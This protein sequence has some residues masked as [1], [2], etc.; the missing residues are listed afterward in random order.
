MIGTEG[1]YHYYMDGEMGVTGSLLDNS[2]LLLAFIEGYNVLGKDNYLNIAINLADYSLENLYDW[3]SGGFFERNSKDNEIYAPGDNIIL[4]KPGQ[5]NGVIVYALLKLYKITNNDSYLNAA[6]K[7]IGNKFD[8][9][10]GL[11][12]GY[13][14]VKSAQFILQNNLLREF[15]ALNLGIIEKEKQD[16]F[17]LNDTA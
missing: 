5:E 6:M 13:Y 2:Y 16:N 11:D 8:N 3:N 15:N 17:W 14:Y 4:S 10:G 7:T 1:A 12:R 9:I